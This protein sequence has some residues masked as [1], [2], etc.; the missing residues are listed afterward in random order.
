MT[1]RK[2]FAAFG[3]AAMLAIALVATTIA[4]EEASAQT[5]VPPTRNI[6]VRDGAN[7][8]EVVIAWDAVPQ[9]RYYRIGYV[10]METDYNRAKASATGEWI[11]A[12]VY[13]DV[14]ARNIPVSGGR[15]EYTI[16][17]LDQGVRHAFTVL[18]TDS[19][20]NNIANVG[21]TFTWPSNPRW[22]FLTVADRGGACPTVPLVVNPGGHDGE[23]DICPITGLPIPAGGYLGV[24]DTYRWSNAW[25]RLDSAAEVPS[26]TFNGS[27]FTP[28]EGNKYLRL[29]STWNNQTGENLYFWAGGD[30]NLS[31]DAGIGFVA[32][33]DDD[34]LDTS[35]VPNRATRSACDIW[36]VPA[37][38]DVAVYAVHGGDTSNP[39]LYRID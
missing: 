32:A 8:G 1:A 18:T 9:A 38:A 22:R 34:W 16:L 24:G 14:N 35:P 25:F 31:T 39:V 17:R 23:G 20:F 21:A 37:A 15:A 12:F 10:N 26:V 36:I 3:V 6:T 19:F 13:V 30:S 5:N 33:S 29:C 11:E 2:F 28:T 27:T 7:P 4:I